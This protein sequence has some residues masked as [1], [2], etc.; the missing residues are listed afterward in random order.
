MILWSRF[1]SLLRAILQRSGTEREMDTELRFH[2]NAYAEDLVR[3]GIPR[4]E[5]LRRARIEFGGIEQAKEQCRDARGLNLI[6]SLIQDIHYGLRMSAK[7]PGF[8]AVAVLTLAL[9]I[10]ANTAIFGLVDSVLL[11]RIPFREPQRLVNIWTLEADGDVHT[12]IPAQYQAVQDQSQSF[13]RIAAAGWADYFYGSEESTPQTIPGFL[14]TANWMPTLGIRPW[15]GR[16][17]R[18]EEQTAGRDAVVLLSYDFWHKR[19]HADPEIVGKQIILN[20]RHVAIIGVLPRSLGPYFQDLEIFA[21]LVIDSY[22]S[23]GNLMGGKTRVEILAR[24]RPEVTLAQANSE[25]DIIAGRLHNPE[26]PAD[27]ADRLVVQ[28]FADQFEHPGP[29]ERNARHGL[30]MTAVSAGIVLLIACAN[31]A[32]LLLAR[33]VKRQREV[34]V[35]AVLGCSR[36]R[37]IRQLLTEGMILSFCGGA[38]ALLVSQWGAVII[39]NTASGLIP[40]AYLQVNAHVFLVTLAISLL[41]AL[42]FGLIPALLLIRVGLNQSLKDAASKATAGAHSLRFRN[43][44]VAG[45]VALGMVLLVV[46]GLLAR[47]LINVKSASIGYDPRNVLTAS[48]RL[49]PGGYASPSDRARLMREVADRM[50]SMPGVQSVGIADSL[51]M[52]GADSAR[53]SIET[54]A[55]QAQPVEEE[56]W[57]VCVNPDYFLTLKVPMLVGHPFQEDEHDNVAIINETFAK[58]YFPDTSPIGYHVAFV[59]SR[60]PSRRIVGVVSDFRQRNPE[61]DLRPLVYFPIAQL[62]PPRWSMAIRVRA[63]SDLPDISARISNWLQPVAPQLYWQMGTLQQLISNSESL[64]MRRP[65][66]VLV[67]SFGSLALLLVI[68]GVFGVTSYSVA[69]RT[70][71]I[72]IRVAL[73]ASRREIARL[74]LLDC[75]RVVVVGLI[76]GAFFAFVLA[77]F[78]PT[79]GIGW[80]GSGVFLYHVSRADFVTYFSAALLLTIV[81]LTASWSPAVRATRVEPTV[82]LRYE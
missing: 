1:R 80:S 60:S 19:F 69:E 81:V 76:S 59:G 27:R 20:R 79:E 36:G 16:N 15:L 74:V 66:I 9:G 68:V 44:L 40:G 23:H 82:A 5:A 64:T 37:M 29:T 2:L 18:E 17:F 50:R 28:S 13:E 72:G 67:A 41:C 71:E 52:E 46:F 33:G 65:I 54:S 22:L 55:L 8:T 53:L 12:P 62:A 38:V 24:L 35:R 26:I 63:V 30:G 77:S 70:R 61:E 34:A 25:I 57:F 75:L 3:S 73:G 78:L 4:E 45:Q 32:S 31:V 39:S 49:P 43:A 21:P 10:G 47:S 42:A 11:R 51:P 58:K 6:D 7:N 48:T 14:V 56:V